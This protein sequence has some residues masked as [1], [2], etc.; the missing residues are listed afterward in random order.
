M[1]LRVKE[2]CKQKGILLKDLAKKLNITDVGLQQIIKGNPT[3]QTLERIADAL[4]VDF[5]ELFAKTNDFVALVDDAG[6]LHKFDN[7]EALQKWLKSTYN[8]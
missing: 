5:V 1:K 2:I 7:A 6:K 3:I 4:G 8:I